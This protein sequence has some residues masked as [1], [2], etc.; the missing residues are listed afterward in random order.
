M[1]LYGK[2]KVAMRKGIMSISAFFL[3]LMLCV[4]S[5][6]ESYKE[7][8]RGYQE[9][10]L[11]DVG[12]TQA[13]LDFRTDE[14]INE[15]YSLIQENEIHYEEETEYMNSGEPISPFGTIPRE[16][17]SIRISMVF[18]L[19]SNV[20]GRSR[21]ESILTFVDYAWSEGHPQITK[22]DGI[23]VNWDNSLFQMEP[24][25]F[26]SVDY[27]QYP[28]ETKVATNQQVDP[29]KLNQGGLGYEAELC[30][31][32]GVILSGSA[33]FMLE[34]KKTIYYNENGNTNS[35]TINV[36]YVHNKNA[37]PFQSISF[38]YNGFGVVVN[39]GI[40]QDSVGVNEVVEYSF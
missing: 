5:Y 34:T 4:P 18:F 40:L 15:L 19:G 27:W 8:D 31:L 21:I 33:Q 37:L 11:L 24:G 39:P 38:S 14:E 35:D 17:M 29:Q 12:M 2:E 10:A 9:K 26:R 20:N 3:V 7:S 28:G 6:A 22:T 32:E 23:T 30:P 1:R 16:D 13:F 25:S 36:E